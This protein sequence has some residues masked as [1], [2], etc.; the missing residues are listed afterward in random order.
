MKLAHNET[1]NCGY[2]YIIIERYKEVLPSPRTITPK[3]EIFAEF[4]VK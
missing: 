4:P 3:G 1:E 2:I